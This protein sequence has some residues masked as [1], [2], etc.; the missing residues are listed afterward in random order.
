MKFLF[1]NSKETYRGK[2]QKA[3]DACAAGGVHADL[4]SEESKDGI[5]DY[6]ISN[7]YSALIHRNEHGRLFADGSLPWAREAVGKGLPVLSMDFGYFDHYKTVA[8]DFY[9]RDL[10]SGIHEQWAG[11]PTAVHWDK[12]PRYVRKFRAACLEKIARADGS[13]YAGK[14]GVWMQWNTNLLR[15]ELEA[16][17]QQWEW[18]NRV[19][20]K[21]S[22]LG[23]DPVVKMGIVDHSE[24]YKRTVPKIEAGIKLVSDKAKIATSNPRAAY[25]PHANWRML[26]G[27]SYHVILC[28]SVSH[29][30]VLT[31][32]PVIATGQSWFNALRVFDEYVEWNSPL[33]RPAVN[34][35]ARSKWVNWWLQKQAP[36]AEAPKRL[37]ETLEAAKSYFRETSS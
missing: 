7:G 23:L 14:V 8:F 5:V 29:L 35:E 11:L 9:R 36:W 4:W 21:I 34:H 25:D 26:A 18:I 37:L 13:A 2:I 15:P 16:P 28:S 20:G 33:V 22:V 24:I 32:R 27:C 19:C 10:S 1:V 17:M 31:D 6:A 3:R 30:M 12:A